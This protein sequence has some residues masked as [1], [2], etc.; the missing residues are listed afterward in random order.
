MK[1]NS[2]WVIEQKVKKAWIAIDAALTEDVCKAMLPFYTREN[3][4][5]FRVRRYVPYI[6][7]SRTFIR[8]QPR[9][10]P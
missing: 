6:P 3:Q 7:K 2:V 8:V 10:K 4:C 5:G 1:K 9:R